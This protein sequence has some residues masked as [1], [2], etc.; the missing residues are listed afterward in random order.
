MFAP[1]FALAA[2]EDVTGISRGV[3]FQLIEALGVLERQRVADDLVT[4][5]CDDEAWR[6]HLRWLAS[7][8]IDRQRD[9]QTSLSFLDSLRLIS[10]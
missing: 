5:Y 9:G 6:V 2:A 8:P 4:W 1:L 7:F 3:A 10:G